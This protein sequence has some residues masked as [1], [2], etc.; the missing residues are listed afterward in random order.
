[1]SIDDKRR[2]IDPDHSKISIQRQC[3]LVGLSR[4]S[5]YYQASP[6]LE[7]PEN[8]NLMRLIDEQYTRT[9]VDPTVKTVNQQ[10]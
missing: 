10:I 5:W 7:S 9:M 8:L 6:A 1:M 4:S 3:E 2:C